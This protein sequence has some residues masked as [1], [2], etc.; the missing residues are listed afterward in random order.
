MVAV[1]SVD[2]ISVN[3]VKGNINPGAIDAI[4][5]LTGEDQFLAYAQNLLNNP[6]A[7][8][9]P[10]VEGVSPISIAA[11]QPSKGTGFELS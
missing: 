6:T 2:Q 1:A 11:V 4:G 10:S 7:L 9:I 3:N 8:D 5:V